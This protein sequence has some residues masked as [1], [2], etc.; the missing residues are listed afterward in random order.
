[1]GGNFIPGYKQNLSY[2]YYYIKLYLPIKIDSFIGDVDD[3]ETGDS[4]NKKEIII[5]K[6]CIK[7]ALYC[8]IYTFST[9]Y[10]N[11]YRNK[12]TCLV[13]ECCQLLKVE[14]VLGK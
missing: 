9:K 5:K 4:V 12:R 14:K 2:P 10:S 13:S 3:S 1:M 7:F 8:S 11:K 6:V